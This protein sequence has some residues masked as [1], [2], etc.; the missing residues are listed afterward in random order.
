MKETGK[1]LKNLI[2]AVLTPGSNEMQNLNLYFN[3]SQN[4]TIS[5]QGKSD[6]HLSGYFE[7]NSSMEEEGMY[8]DELED[9]DMEDMKDSDES[10]DDEKLMANLSKTTK[11]DKD[12]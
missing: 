6:V 7:P 5:C 4:V 1:E 2:L 12:V 9:D 8:G 3:V 11:K 10:D